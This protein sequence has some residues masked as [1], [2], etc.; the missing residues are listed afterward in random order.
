MD[1]RSKRSLSFDDYEYIHRAT[2]E[3]LDFWQKASAFTAF[4][5]TKEEIFQGM[6]IRQS[7]FLDYFDG[8]DPRDMVKYRF[9]RIIPSRKGW[10]YKTSRKKFL[11][12]ID[13]LAKESV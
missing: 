8:Y 11:D 1:E 2:R 12:F 6:S 9:P 10:P 5:N 13:K 4:S 3:F 7:I